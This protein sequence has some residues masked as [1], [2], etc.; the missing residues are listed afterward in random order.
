MRTREIHV[1]NTQPENTLFKKINWFAIFGHFVSAVT[2]MGLIW[3][4]DPVIIPY[5]E[6]LLNLEKCIIFTRLSY[7]KQNIRHK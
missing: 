7:W 4:R 2:M 3:D 6:T 5:T 1:A